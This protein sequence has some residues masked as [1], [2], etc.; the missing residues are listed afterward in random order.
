MPTGKTKPVRKPTKRA[1]PRSKAAVTPVKRRTFKRSAVSKRAVARP[2]PARDAELT[3]REVEVLQKVAGGNRSREIGDKLS[4][5][6]E[7]VKV[8]IRHIMDKLRAK[9]R[10]QAFAIAVRRGIIEV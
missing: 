3:A 4:I 8:H 5:S 6:E 10:T 1:A 9:N 2:K 7:T